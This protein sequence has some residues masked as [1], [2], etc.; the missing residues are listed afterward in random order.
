MSRRAA[1]SRHCAGS[2]AVGAANDKRRIGGVKRMPVRPLARDA[3][4]WRMSVN[5][6]LVLRAA[7]VV[8]SVLSV[9]STIVKV[10]WPHSGNVPPKNSS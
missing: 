6:V 10:A 8:A 9:S 5:A 7:M 1:E 4:G 3:P 2:A